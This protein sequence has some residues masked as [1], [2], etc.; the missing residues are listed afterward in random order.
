MV[1]SLAREGVKRVFSIPGGQLLPVYDGIREH[2][3]VDMIV[4]RHEG[5]SALM[6]CGYAMA[7]GSV[8]TVMS[9]VGAGVIYEAG[10]LLLAWLER[11]PVM[12]ISPQVQSYKMKPIQESLQACDQD[13]IFRPYTKFRSIIY[14]YKRIPQLVRRAIKVAV[15][16]EPG[17]VHLDLPVDVIFEY[18]KISESGFEKYFP[19]GNFRFEGKTVPN[20]ESVEKAV[21]LIKASRKPLAL[22]GRG[23]RI[24]ARDGLTRLLETAPIPVVTSVPGY[25]AVKSDYSGRVGCPAQWLDSDDIGKLADA[26]LILLF[27]ADEE[28]SRLAIK[29]V[30]L[31]PSVKIVQSAAMSSAIGSLTPVDV[32]LLG[33]V[34][35]VLDELVERVADHGVPDGLDGAWIGDIVDTGKKLGKINLSALGRGP[36]IDGMTATVET[37]SELLRPEDYV[38]CEGPMAAATAMTTLKHPGLHRTFLMPDDY[39]PGAGLPVSLGIKAASPKSRVYLVSET[40]RFKRH[41]REFQTAGRYKL[42]VTMFLFQD[43]PQKPE[44]EVDFT[45]LARSLGVDAKHVPEPVEEVTPDVVAE[46]FASESGTLFDASSS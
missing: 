46:S 14:H 12:S 6:A 19:E 29:I 30:R 40:S 32:G 31:N 42:P 41:S 15:A 27:E 11:L 8:A 1:E 33:S 7:T 13:E 45:A 16:P 43:N 39:I 2:P 22:V 4:P 9:T 10:G 26:D 17:P 23:A 44:E 38:V 5:A 37:I 3:D 35:A 34:D 25:S 36:R 21:S 20:E 28:T 24:N 18:N